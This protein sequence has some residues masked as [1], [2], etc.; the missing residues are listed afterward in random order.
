MTH[1]ELQGKIRIKQKNC[2][3]PGIFVP[4]QFSFCLTSG[5]LMGCGRK[6]RAAA[7][8]VPERMMKEV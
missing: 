8:A 2:R 1:G 5:S 7:L 4:G 6:C 3:W